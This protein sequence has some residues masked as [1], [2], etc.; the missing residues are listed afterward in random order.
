MKPVF[1]Y[2]DYRDFLKDH[3]DHNKKNRFFSFRYIAAK[4][5]IDASLYAKILNKQRHISTAKVA[6]L[7]D[8][9]KLKRTE[10]KYFELLVRFNRAKTTEKPGSILK[11]CYLYRTHLRFCWKR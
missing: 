10:K 9:L 2:L 8:F 4:T 3:Y 11:K 6:E 7:C 5:G 1:E